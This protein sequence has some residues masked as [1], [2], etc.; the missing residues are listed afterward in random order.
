MG[1][2][3]KGITVAVLTQILFYLVQVA[4]NVY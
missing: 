2:T 3:Y 4:S 1:E